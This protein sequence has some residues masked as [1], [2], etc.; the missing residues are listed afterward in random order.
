[1]IEEGAK[2]QV[3]NKGIKAFVK[4]EFF[5]ELKSL[6]DKLGTVNLAIMARTTNYIWGIIRKVKNRVI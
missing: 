1:M 2:D 5:D 3:F 4:G 6:E